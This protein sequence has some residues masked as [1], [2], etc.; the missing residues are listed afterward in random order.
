MSSVLT[1]APGLVLLALVVVAMDRAIRGGSL[2]RNG[3]VGFRTRATTS[4]D[5]AWEAGNAAALPVL[6][7]AVVAALVAVAAAVVVALVAPPSAR[8]GVGLAAVGAGY[9][10]VLGLVVIGG[11]RADRAARAVRDRPDAPG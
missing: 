11:V 7:P 4:S 2:A 6:R 5:P 9:A 3:L 10:A 8:E 1:T